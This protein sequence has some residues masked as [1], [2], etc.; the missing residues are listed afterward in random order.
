MTVSPIAG[1]L[2]VVETRS[3]L[4]LP[5]TTIGF[6]LGK[7]VLLGSKNDMKM[8]QSFLCKERS[9]RNSGQAA[10]KK[11]EHPGQVSLGSRRRL[12]ELSPYEHAPARRNHGGPLADGI[13]NGWADDVGP[14]CDKVGNRAGTP[15]RST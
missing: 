11:N 13:R 14:G 12:R 3:V 8:N 2:L 5:T 7:A 4:M 15:N 1:I 6:W 9:E 10:K